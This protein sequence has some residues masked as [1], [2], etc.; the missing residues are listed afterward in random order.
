M[1]LKGIHILSSS[2]LIDILISILKQILSEKLIKRIFVHKTMDTVY[3]HIPKDILPSEFGGEERS[4]KELHGGYFYIT[5][6][7]KCY[8]FPNK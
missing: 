3:E 5:F 8:F 7:V 2:K 6:K 1:K 4:I